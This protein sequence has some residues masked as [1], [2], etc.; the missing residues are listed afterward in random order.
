SKAYRT[1]TDVLIL[2]RGA[3]GRYPFRTIEQMLDTFAKQNFRLG[4]VAGFVYADA[5]VNAFIADEAHKHQIV[6]VPSDVQNLRNLLTGV[7]DGFLADRIAAATTAWR[8][9][10][11]AR[12]EEHPMRFSTSIHFMLSR[13]SQTPQMVARLDDA[14]D[15]LRRSGELHRIA[16]LYALPVLI[17]Q[18]IDSQWF[19]ILAFIGTVAFAL[20]GVVLA[21]GGQYTLFGALVLATLPAVGGGGGRGLVLS[22]GTLGVARRRAGR[23]C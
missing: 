19:R 12:I 4:V 1:E 7:V 18:T 22:R 3:S 11:G 17:N 20:S 14:I 8:R 23:V 10:E 5:R 21:Y 9:Q 13:A 6:A 16:D 2:P 15:E